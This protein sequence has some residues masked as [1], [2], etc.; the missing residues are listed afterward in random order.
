MIL[1]QKFFKRFAL[2]LFFLFVVNSLANIFFWYQSI[3]WFDDFTHFFGG[4]TGGLFL[5]WFFYNRYINLIKSKKNIQLILLHSASFVF[6]ALLWEFME[7][8]VQDLFDIGNVLAEKADSVRDVIFGLFG[9]SLS[10]LYYFINLKK[11][12]DVG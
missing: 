8:S 10:L 12:N 1:K 7:F 3:Y 2:T 4:V 9:N 5:L 6:V 11:Q